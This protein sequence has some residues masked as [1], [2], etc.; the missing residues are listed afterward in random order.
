MA[1]NFLKSRQTRYTAYAGTYILVILGVLGAINF[2]ANR[3]D[4]SYDSTSNKQFSLSDQTEKVVK[5]LNRDVTITYFDETTRFPQAKDLLDRYSAMSPKLHLEFVDPVKKPQQAKSAG[6]RRDLSILVDSGLR[7]EEAKSLTEEEVTGALI[8]SLKS[9]ERNVCF[10]SAANEHSIG[11]EAPTGYSLMKQLLERDNY[12]T[13]EINFKTAAPEAGK[14]LAIGQAP[15]AGA[16]EV[17]KDC[18]ATVVGGPQL[19][20]PQP[21]VDALK[22]YVEGGGHALF[23]LDNVLRIGRG[24]PTAENKALTDVLSSWGVTAN[25][26]LVLDL[27]GI[28]NM[29]GAGPEIPIILAYE[30]SPITRPLARVPTAFPV[31]RSLDIKSGDK[32]KVDKLFGTTADSIAVN[33]VSASGAI[34]PKKGKKGPFTLGAS[35]TYQGTNGR[36]VVV[37]TSQWTENRAMGSRTLGNRDLFMNMINWLTADED[38]ISIRPKSTEDRPLTMTAQKLNLVF[39]LSVIIFPLGVV[40]FGMATWWK[41][42]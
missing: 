41:R 8:R 42:R 4:K 18:L 33:E 1:S 10:V 6:Y 30:A 21:I 11:D 29:F 40:G 27:S 25:K 22:R 28:G 13:R 12:K 7:K 26:D 14:P 2:L 24:E 16:V 20:Y 5:N 35:G 36:F 19:D 34:D 32:T 31:P 15:V 37:G 38:L 17:P 9:G 39:W 23:L 3:Y